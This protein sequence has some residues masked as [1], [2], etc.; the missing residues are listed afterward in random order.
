M[1]CTSSWIHR[2]VN[3]LIDWLIQSSNSRV[4]QYKYWAKATTMMWS[5]CWRRFS[6]P[7]AL[8]KR[9]MRS[10]VRSVLCGRCSAISSYWLLQIAA[11]F[12]AFFFFECLHVRRLF[13]FPFTPAE[14]DV[15]CCGSVCWW[16]NNIV[17]AP[18][19]DPNTTETM[20]A[21]CGTWAYVKPLNASRSEHIYHPPLD[22][23]FTPFVPRQQPGRLK[24]ISSFSFN[25]R[26]LV[27]VPSGLWANES[28]LRFDHMPDSEP[29][30]S[31]SHALLDDKT[32]DS[33]S[34]VKVIFSVSARLLKAASPT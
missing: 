30:W 28:H 31:S 17:T 4:F 9:L 29:R 1:S 24:L 23:V 6:K 19:T 10:W 16:G 21:V 3:N 12:F 34:N 14:E 32:S 5:W 33:R 26:V 22:Y 15:C 13:S 20:A 8:Q 18:S 2:S 25:C 27:N 11:F 7:R